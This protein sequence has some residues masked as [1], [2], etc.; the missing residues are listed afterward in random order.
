MTYRQAQLIYKEEK[1]IYLKDGKV[2]ETPATETAK[3]SHA[4][5]GESKVMV[6]E[7]IIERWRI[8]SLKEA[9]VKFWTWMEENKVDSRN[10]YIVFTE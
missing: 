8:K 5:F 6:T 2:C 10:Y 4:I 3:L 1:M 9:N 7:K